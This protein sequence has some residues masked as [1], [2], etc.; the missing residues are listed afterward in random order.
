MNFFKVKF[1]PSKLEDYLYFCLSNIIFLIIFISLIHK[2]IDENNKNASMGEIMLFIPKIGSDYEEKR[3]LIFKQLSANSLI[4]SVNKLENN[5]IK[6]LLSDLLKN[7]KVSDDIIPDVYDVKVEKSKPLNLTLINNKIK[8]IIPG[9]LLKEL[10]YK[11]KNI[12]I[13]YFTIFI[14][15][16]FITLLNN[17]F[18]V[19]NILSKIKNYINLSRYFGVNDAVIIRNF[20][21]SF[22]VLLSLVFLFSYLIFKMVLKKYLY[23]NLLN[24]F[25][26]IYLVICFIYSLIILTI[27]SI[28]CKMYMK[29]LNVL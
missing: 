14:I 18:L 1:F 10:N 23:F 7:I 5:E 17:F 21:I 4:I 15:L 19:K 3:D 12:S 8:K 2:N 27:F 25:F 29:K 6:K 20:N 22:F 16:I 28:Q 24:N 26:I 11:K 13:L 9:A